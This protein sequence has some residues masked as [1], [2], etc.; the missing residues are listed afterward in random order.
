MGKERT[1][2][3]RFRSAVI[4]YTMAVLY[5]YTTGAKGKEEF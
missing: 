4:P 1:P 2:L 3:A 5:K